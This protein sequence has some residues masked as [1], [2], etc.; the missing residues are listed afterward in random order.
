VVLGGDGIGLP[1]GLALEGGGQ[2]HR[3]RAVEERLGEAGGDGRPR[4]DPGGERARGAL[5]LG[6]GNDA[7]DQTYPERFGRVDDLDALTWERTDKADALK[8]AAT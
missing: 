4:R 7:V 3:G 2:I 1:E 5:Q 6:R 8:K